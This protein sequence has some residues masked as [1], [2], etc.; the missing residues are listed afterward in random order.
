MKKKYKEQEDDE[1]SRLLHMKIIGSK[2]KKEEELKPSEM[3]KKYKGPKEIKLNEIHKLTNSPNEGDNLSFAIPMCA[4]YSAIQT[5]KYKIKLV[6]GNTKKGKVADSCISYFLKNAT[7]EKEKELIKN[8]SMDELG[9][10][11]IANCT[12]DLKE[13]KEL[14][15]NNFV[16]KGRKK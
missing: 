13:L 8:I 11:I 2:M 9:N 5:H 15:K 6:P 4:P 1:E 14:S 16:Q 12:P 10:C 3:Q 7:N